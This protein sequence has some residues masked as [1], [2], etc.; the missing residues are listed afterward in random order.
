MFPLRS[1]RNPAKCGVKSPCRLYGGKGGGGAVAFLSK[2]PYSSWKK[3]K[4]EIENDKNGCVIPSQRIRV[5][6]SQISSLGLLSS[7]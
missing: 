7:W 4:K 2:N 5:I 1:D 6:L 3:I